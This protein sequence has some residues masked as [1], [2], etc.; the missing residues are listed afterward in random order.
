MGKVAVLLAD[1][2]EEIEAVTIIDV[3]RRAEQEVSVVAVG[4]ALAVGAHDIA[5]KTD[6]D[7]GQ[8]DPAV[9]DAVVLPGG[10]PGA[11]SLRDE[12]RVLDLVRRMHESKKVVGAICAAPIALEAAGILSGKKATSYPGFELPSAD[13][14]QAR[15][16]EDDNVLTS[17]G[18]G[19][20]LEFALTLVSRLVSPERA[21][22]LKQRM[23]V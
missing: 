1:G 5:I 14:Q 15:V 8:L 11:T 20:A 2:F 17:R 6:T 9:L 13:Y 19:T 22:D 7:L 18:P 23:L 10:L 4:S 21:A 16:V 3:L 12:P